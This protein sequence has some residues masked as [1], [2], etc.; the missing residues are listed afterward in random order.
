MNDHRGTTERGALLSLDGLE[1]RYGGAIHALRGVRL[2]I[3]DGEIVAVLGTNGAGKTT[4]LRALTGLLPAHKGHITGGTL[5]LAGTSLLG[6]DPADVVRRGIAQVMEGRRVFAELT[7]EENLR[8]GAFTRADK[9]AVAADFDRVYSLFPIL[10]E[11][12]RATAGYL[13][14]GEQQ[15][16]AI[17]RALLAGP[18]LLILD[19]PSLGLAPA[20]VRRIRDNLT[21][22][23]RQGTTVL[24]V[25]QNAR[26]ALSIADRGYVLETGR[27]VLDGPAATLLADPEVQRLYLGI[28][29]REGVSIRELARQ[30]RAEQQGV[31]SR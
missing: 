14:G 30:R 2:E 10:A 25:E 7:V 23:N 1:V 31:V 11:R 4:L 22:I 17:A 19:E 18:R 26:M 16:V 24:L 28:G 13:S 15:M 5:T 3:S 12:R 20:M 29:E 8:T 21:E 9:R 6:L 27:V